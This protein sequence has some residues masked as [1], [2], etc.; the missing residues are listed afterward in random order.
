MWTHKAWPGRFLPPSLPARERLRAYAGWCNAVE[1]NTTFYATPARETVVTWAEQIGP[2]FRLVVKVPKLVTH[3]RRFAGVE[4]PMRA[5]LDAIEPLG[6]RAVLWTQLPG[7][8]APSDVDALGRF[9]RRLPPGRRRAVE[10]RHPAFFTDPAAASRLEE[11]LAG[12]NAEWIPF[13][14]T[15][16]FGS[17]P[18]TEAEQESWTKKPRV[19]RRTR[20]LTDH[21]IVRYLGRDSAE[22]TTEGWQPWT[23]VVADWLRDGRSPTVF[24][25]TP[26]NNDAPAL[27]R[28]FHDDV[29]ALVPELAALPEP[30][31]VGPATLF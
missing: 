31:P 16:F 5:F 26:D 29:R 20:A 13:D 24:I 6:D 12:V 15:V 17:P 4:V 23:E 30:E 19:P 25:H 3:E 1:G 11:T 10:V 8:F 9:L 28:H 7:A 2:D 22:E 21:P 14:T 18:V 27:A